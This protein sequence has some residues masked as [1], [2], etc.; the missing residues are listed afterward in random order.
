MPTVIITRA[1]PSV[2]GEA[3]SL[4]ECPQRQFFHSLFLLLLLETPSFEM[5]YKQ[6]SSSKH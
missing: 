4:P 5:P 1:K 6:E 3:A 2:D